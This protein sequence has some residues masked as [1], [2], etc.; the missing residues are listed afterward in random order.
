MSEYTRTY[1]IEANRANSVI[2]KNATGTN[3]AKF[4]TSTD[5]NLRRGDR[6]SIQ[7]CV[8]ESEGA[9]TGEQTIE[10]TGQNVVVD[11]KER[12]YKDNA[13]LLQIGYYITNNQ[14][15]NT[16]LPFRIPYNNCN[17]PSGTANNNGRIPSILG[18]TTENA[19]TGVG[20]YP[21][22]GWGWNPIPTKAFV[23][24][25]YQLSNLNWVNNIN[26]GDIVVGL[27][28]A[29][30]GDPGVG[31]NGVAT[32]DDN[33]SL[34]PVGTS[35]VALY[36]IPYA[37]GQQFKIN[38]GTPTEQ[39]TTKIKNFNMTRVK[40]EVLGIGIKLNI[41]IE[42]YTVTQPSNQGDMIIGYV[43]NLETQKRLGMGLID[44]NAGQFQQAPGVNKITNSTLNQPDLKVYTQ[45]GAIYWNIARQWG[46]ITPQCPG[47]GPASQ[48]GTR[49]YNHYNYNGAFNNKTFI[50]TRNDYQGTRIRPDGLGLTPKLEP[51]TAFVLIDIEETFIS[52]TDLAAKITDQLHK[53]LPRIQNTQ[54]D[55][56][57][58]L[59]DLRKTNLN[60][61]QVVPYS[62]TLP[63]YQT[64][65]NST[66]G[67]YTP[68]YFSLWDTIPPIMRG[69]NCLKVLPA[70]QTP[71]IDWGHQSTQY[72]YDPIIDED[73]AYLCNGLKGTDRYN[74]YLWGGTG[75]QDF[76]RAYAG[77]RFLRTSVWD[78]NTTLHPTRNIPKQVILNTQF[79]IVNSNVAT[80]NPAWVASG[81]N[82]FSGNFSDIDYNQPIF[83]N[84]E[85]TEENLSKIQEAFRHY[86]E[87]DPVPEDPSIH[88][89]YTSED[90]DL[91]WNWYYDMDIGM[92]DDSRV[93]SGTLPPPHLRNQPN[94]P[95]S[96][97]W[98][99]DYPPQAFQA[100]NPCG[101]GT[102]L[103]S[104]SHT[105]LGLGRE[106]SEFLGRGLGRL[107]I[108]SR[109]RKNQFSERDG[110]TNWEEYA[111]EFLVN[112]N[113]LIDTL[114]NI[115]RVPQTKASGFI[116]HDLFEWS[117]KYNVGAYPYTY[118]DEDGKPHTFVFFLTKHS[119]KPNNFNPETMNNWKLAPI[120]W[121]NSIG[122]SQSCLDNPK[123]VLMNP[124]Q[125]NL[126]YLND[127]ATGNP[128]TPDFKYWWN[129]VNYIYVGANNPTFSYDPQKNRY[130]F[131][132]LYTPVAFAA[133]EAGS[134][135]PATG[136]PAVG[137]VM[138]TIENST[139]KDIYKTWGNQGN[140]QVPVANR[141]IRD[142]S[143]GIILWD[144][145]L[146][147][148]GWKIPD[149]IDLINFCEEGGSPN[150]ALNE[151]KITNGLTKASKENWEG[152][153]FER[154]GFDYEQLFPRTGRSDNRYNE[155]NYNSSNPATMSEGCKPFKLNS[156]IDI[157]QNF[158]L[159]MFHDNTG[160]S[161]VNNTPLYGLG[162][163][164]NVP[165]NLQANTASLIA[166]NQPSLY[167]SS[168]YLI[169][170]DIVQF[171]YKDGRQS[172]NAM[173]SVMKSYGSGG[174]WY[175]EGSNYTQIVETDR[176][177][178]QINSAIR[179]P[180]TGRLAKVGENSAII[181]KIQRQ[182]ILPT[183]VENV[184]GER[185]P[186]GNHN[187]SALKNIWVGEQKEIS[188]LNQIKERLGAT[189]PIERR[190]NIGRGINPY[191]MPL[192]QYP[193]NQPH[194][195]EGDF[196]SRIGGIDAVIG[197]EKEEIR[198]ER[199]ANLPQFKRDLLEWLVYETLANIKVSGSSLRKSYPKGSLNSAIK[200]ILFNPTLGVKN[201]LNDTFSKYV[202]EGDYNELLLIDDLSNIV[203]DLKKTIG[204]GEDRHVTARGKVS[205]IRRRTGKAT[206]QIIELTPEG[207]SIVVDTLLE[208]G[209][210][211]PDVRP[212]EVNLT[213]IFKQLQRG[214]Q[215]KLTQAIP[216]EE[217]SRLNEE[218]LNRRRTRAIK[219]LAKERQIS[220]EEVRSRFER[221]Q[222]QRYLDERRE[223]GGSGAGAEQEPETWSGAGA[224]AKQEPE[225]EI[226]E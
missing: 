172:T 216:V 44:Y 80:D 166:I 214:G 181:Y 213:G 86:E 92:T 110:K 23:I 79:K 10:F 62:K 54:K 223:I 111:N 18:N 32:N 179:N 134:T 77:D 51:L 120:S 160:V 146:V 58:I 209:A 156:E 122:Y 183:I 81:V 151:A 106:I 192:P 126:T 123:C 189:Q 226:E 142:T 30:T 107:K 42:D 222:P 88:L 74:N 135:A 76:G 144:M 131:S 170:T 50:I 219:R 188:I 169:D 145:Y 104:P 66:P 180:I 78:G 211:S 221:G 89:H 108:Y 72:D 45:G 164:N 4:S 129:S 207:V 157:D 204:I 105:S 121:G 19:D 185:L 168:F 220:V 143:S 152:S 26:V 87:Y 61:S 114:C 149:G 1:L 47:T 75:I 6:V 127:Q 133:M 186:E 21:G 103:I 63:F 38:P 90:Q 13:V 171:D 67:T 55:Y 59:I 65:P 71:G 69:T 41:N 116:N 195:Q 9:G 109:F 15:Y 147:P 173:F 91:D 102:S 162:T 119:T 141:G 100:P 28:F 112:F 85:F 53:T 33:V 70:N 202:G 225:E 210:L 199:E 200:N 139:T 17:T 203:E 115:Y 212:E 96:P 25:Q 217:A 82:Q 190:Q 218:E 101:S 35:R 8:I 176:L 175:S 43:P 73:Y 205:R 196:L 49:N 84:I 20:I 56:D 29:N 215:I 158:Y 3:K 184:E 60:K 124:D 83:T 113:G 159:S 161:S 36:N 48:P 31:L 182:M 16:L 2:D 197:S 140:T 167:T 208:Q 132:N 194:I 11:G 93:G 136:L 5:F 150:T 155:F 137:D 187:F 206:G 99:Q 95:F 165:V 174:Y 7:N 148:E 64:D 117:K 177:I 154:L 178:T 98:L 224:G 94:I 14:E 27:E 125:T 128:V 40:G 130:G 46:G 198:M 37:D 153:L 201:L 52:A 68:G 193:T 24:H 22:S 138:A 57:N 39:I 163:N 191:I 34:F 118:T 12:N 97:N